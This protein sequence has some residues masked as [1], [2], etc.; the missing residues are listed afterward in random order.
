MLTQ[1]ALIQVLLSIERICLMHAARGL[2]LQERAPAGVSMHTLTCHNVQ[3]VIDSWDLL[4]PEN[5]SGSD[6]IDS[7]NIVE[8]SI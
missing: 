1:I 2:H 8:R 5:V 7:Y 6:L 4:V 3:R